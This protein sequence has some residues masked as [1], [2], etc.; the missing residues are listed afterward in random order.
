MTEQRIRLNKAIFPQKTTGKIE[1]VGSPGDRKGTHFPARLQQVAQAQGNSNS[2]PTPPLFLKNLNLVPRQLHDPEMLLK[3]IAE[4][5]CS[6]L[7]KIISL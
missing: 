4:H 3:P 2:P 5:I 7:L 1:S 6:Q